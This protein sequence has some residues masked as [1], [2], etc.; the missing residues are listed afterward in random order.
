MCWKQ[1]HYSAD[2][3]LYNQGYGLPCGHIWLWELDCTEGRA[4]K[5]WFLQTGVL[6]KTP[7]SPLDSMEIKLV[8]LQGNKPWIHVGRT[9]AEAP[10]FQSSDV[11]SWLIGKVPV[12]GKIEGRRGE[13]AGWHHWWNEHE[14]GKTLGDGERQESLV[15]C[16]PWG[17]KEL[18]RTGRLNNNNEWVKIET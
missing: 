11:N 13:M 15:C 3:V 8:S 10:V 7:E 18:D 17:H 4:P 12:A 1:R 5:N 9:D 14:L 6:E 2:K 16:S